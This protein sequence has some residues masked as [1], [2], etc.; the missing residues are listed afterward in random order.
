MLLQLRDGSVTRIGFRVGDT[1]DDPQALSVVVKIK[2]GP[3]LPAEKKQCR[4]FIQPDHLRS[5][6]R[7]EDS[8]S[9]GASPAA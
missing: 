1:E 2:T 6:Q 9:C 8:G 4:R 5:Y 7:G 3:I